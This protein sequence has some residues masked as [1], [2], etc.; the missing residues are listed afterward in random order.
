MGRVVVVAYRPKPGQSQALQALVARHVPLL[1]ARGLATDRAPVVMQAADGTLVEVFEWASAES[2]AQAHADPA[3]TSLW[4][5]FAAACE[6]V[7]LATLAEAQQLFAEF[8]PV[9]PTG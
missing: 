7:P 4:A 8:V 2:V 6:T 1:A 3:V 9:E 5:E